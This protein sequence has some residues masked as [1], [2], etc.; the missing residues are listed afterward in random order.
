MGDGRIESSGNNRRMT[1]RRAQGWIYFPFFFSPLPWLKR[2]SLSLFFF[3][4]SA[5]FNNATGDPGLSRPVFQRDTSLWQIATDVMNMKRN[6]L[7]SPATLSLALPRSRYDVYVVH[8]H[9]HIYIH[10]RWGRG[11]IKPRVPFA[12]RILNSISRVTTY[13]NLIMNRS[14]GIAVILL[15]RPRFALNHRIV[16]EY[17]KESRGCR[18]RVRNDYYFASENV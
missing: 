14:N 12:F 13:L 15:S 5:H 1:N 4:L 11:W 6:P 10:T 3:F 16:S 17:R 7:H 9:T 2:S 18:K 8:T